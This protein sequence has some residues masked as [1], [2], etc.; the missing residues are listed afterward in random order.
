M[1]KICV[2]IPVIAAFLMSGCGKEYV[3]V[4]FAQSGH[5]SDWRTMSQDLAEEA[6]SRD[7]GF[8]L[9]VSDADN[10]EPY[11]TEAVRQFIDEKYDYIVIDPLPS[12]EWGSIFSEADKA[13]IPVI[14]VNRHAAGAE[15]YSA[16]FGPDYTAEGRAAGQEILKMADE[17]A[18]IYVIKGVEGSAAGE[19]RLEGLKEVLEDAGMG[20]KASSGD[21]TIDGGRAAAEELAPE[22]KENPG[23]LVCMNDNMA[24]GA[25]AA[26]DS[27]GITYG[28]EGSVKIA[29]FNGQYSGLKAVLDGRIA[30]DVESGPEAVLKAAEAISNNTITDQENPNPVVIYTMDNLDPAIV[31]ERK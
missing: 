19:G 20:Y 31:E 22:I 4:G 7:K 1:K 8:L 10:Y 18:V 13:G 21:F 30:F 14:L 17:D 12:E 5:E 6:F 16:W 27:A 9:T 29:S 26:L 28:S 15:G 25:M 11:Q 23:I 24:L 2:L 3:R